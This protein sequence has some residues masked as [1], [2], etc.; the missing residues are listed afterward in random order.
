MSD[1]NGFISPGTM[2]SRLT[3][4]QNSGFVTK[5]LKKFALFDERKMAFLAGKSLEPINALLYGSAIGIGSVGAIH[6]YSTVL[7]CIVLS[8]DAIQY[9]TVYSTVKYCIVLCWCNTYT[10]T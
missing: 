6:T 4:W 2:R 9:C 5:F 8:I 1:N 3:K 10:H 7:H